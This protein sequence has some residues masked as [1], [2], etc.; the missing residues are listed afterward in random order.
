M[1]RLADDPALIKLRGQLTVESDLMRRGVFT[2]ADT[3]RPYFTG[4]SYR[5]LYD[6][7][8]Y[9]ESIVQIY[10]G[11]SSD[12]IRNGV[13]IF[14]DHQQPSGMIS[15]SV[16]SNEYHDP[17]HVKPF[18]SQ[19]ALLVAQNYGETGWLLNDR[20]FPRLQRYLDYWLT[21]MD[22][23][24]NGLAE[25]M[26]APHTGMDNQ[27]E[28]AGWWLDRFCE[29]TD[30]NC[31][32]VRECRAFSWLAEQY[33]QLETAAV[34]RRRAD[35]RAAVIRGLLWDEQDGFFYD[36]NARFGNDPMS[37][38]A[39][40]A[41]AMNSAAGER[42]RVKTVAGF[43]PLWAGVATPEQARR[44]VYEHLFNPREFWAP[45]PISAMARNERWYSS[46][47]HPADLGC[48]W[49]GKTWVSTNYMIYH[50]LRW[51][52]Y[53][54]L[55]SLVAHYTAALVRQAGNCEYY[56]AETGKGCGLDPFW[57][58]SLAGHFMEYED[59]LDTSVAAIP[60]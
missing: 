30:L 18:L 59:T 36:R 51:Y 19:M 27:H 4:Y 53:R 26:S 24:G 42:I 60:E 57:G 52:G 2:D 31:Y 22:M 47:Y 45:Y 17:E 40:W 34:Y 43:A 25:W 13:T 33:G 16:P 39:G 49:R 50:G 35:E 21:E 46:D 41:S 23:D 8:Q 7:D 29:G 44:L 6:W 11:W 5:T 55:A 20:Y 10:M 12:Y 54:E 15:R 38:R 56:D 28:R 37:R 1:N 3:G 48:D 58:W 14:L 32:I 9:F